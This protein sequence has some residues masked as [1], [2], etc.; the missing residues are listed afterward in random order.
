M[1]KQILFSPSHDT[2]QITI[3]IEIKIIFFEQRIA[4]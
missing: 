4:R 3:I 2:T 1:I